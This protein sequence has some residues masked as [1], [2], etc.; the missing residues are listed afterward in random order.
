[1]AASTNRRSAAFPSRD[2]GVP[3]A[4]KCTVASAASAISVE[5]RSRP[6]SRAEAS[7]SGRPGSKNGGRPA[8]SSWILPGSTSMPMTSWPS[9]AIAEACTAP[10]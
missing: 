3:T 5:N 10:R 2:C 9:S 8:W 7:T 4:T 6:V 1:M